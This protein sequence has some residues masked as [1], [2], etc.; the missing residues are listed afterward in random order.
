MALFLV[1]FLMATL[2]VALLVLG[3]TPLFGGRVIAARRA[4]WI[5]GLLVGFFPCL[6]VVRWIVGLFDTANQV[7]APAVG[8]SL[9]GVW[10]CVAI[11]MVFRSLFPKRMPT[12]RRSQA[13]NPFEPAAVEDDEP[14]REAV[15]EVVLEETP[16]PTPAKTVPAKAPPAKAAPAKAAPAKKPP[17]RKPAKDE[18]NPFDFA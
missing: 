6:F 13:A 11:G 4:R 14:M 1:G 8:W 10:L 9:F 3:E 17:P 16:A 2:G 12:Q 18:G 7:P 5:G 15:D